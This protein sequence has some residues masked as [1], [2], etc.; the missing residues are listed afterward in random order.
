MHS[1]R[2][3]RVVL[4]A[5]LSLLSIEAGAVMPVI[6]GAAI[7]QLAS[8]L[9]QL[10]EQYNLLR[11]TYEMGQSQLDGI[12]SIRDFNSGNYG[13]GDLENSLDSLRNW[14]NSA[15]DWEGALNNVAGG[16]PVRYAQ[17]VKA[18]EASHPTLSETEYL[19][20]GSAGHL[21]Q[22]KQKQAVNRAASVQATYAFNDINKHL[23]TIHKLSAQIDKTPNTK[24]AMDLNARLIT[25]LAYISVMHLKLQTIVSQQMSQE[26]ADLLAE[27][28][29]MVRFYGLTGK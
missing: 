22:Y 8:Q 10:R 24:S 16:N 3:L 18:Y 15:D 9:S 1:R 17:L 11:N 25:E 12:K 2:G 20:G 27:E 13:L 4:M 28:A 26:N 23:K 19:K 29:D 7:A 6:D 21:Q 5:G 14:Q